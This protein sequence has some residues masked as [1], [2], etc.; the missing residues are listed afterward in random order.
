MC[1]GR[2]TSRVKTLVPVRHERRRRWGFGLDA[3][4][5]ELCREKQAGWLLA[6]RRSG[7]EGRHSRPRRRECSPMVMPDADKARALLGKSVLG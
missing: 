3:A 5:D 1:R 4:Q 2:S 6:L 7:I